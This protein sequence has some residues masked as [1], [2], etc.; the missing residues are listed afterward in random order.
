MQNTNNKK[1]KKVEYNKIHYK[2]IP[3]D[4]PIDEAEQLKDYCKK[5]QFKVNSFIRKLISEKISK[6]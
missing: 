2:R 3:L 1:Q 6:K 4:L 5:N